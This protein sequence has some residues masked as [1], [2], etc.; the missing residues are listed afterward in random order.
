ME[1]DKKVKQ[2]FCYFC[3]GKQGSYEMIFSGFV[4]ASN[5][6]IAYTRVAGMLLKRDMFC[7]DELCIQVDKERIKK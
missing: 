4:F 3:T 7:L 6:D 1:K 2:K 5:I